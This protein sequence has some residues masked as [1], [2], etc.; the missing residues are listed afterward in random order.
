[1]PS[2]CSFMKPSTARFRAWGSGG[3]PGGFAAVVVKLLAL[4]PAGRYQT[5][6]A[7][8]RRPRRSAQRAVCFLP[9]QIAPPVRYPVLV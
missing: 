2:A 7:L 4:D 3:I 5:A 9:T 8:P 1:M 6:A